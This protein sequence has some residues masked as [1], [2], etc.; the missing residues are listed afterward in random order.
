MTSKSNIC[1]AALA[2]LLVALIGVDCCY[3]KRWPEYDD[4]EGC[5]KWQFNC[6]FPGYDIGSQVSSGE[7]CGGLCINN[8][9]CNAFS[10]HH[11]TCYM[12]NIPA[13]VGRSPAE[14]GV[15]G[16]LPWKF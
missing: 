4:G 7:E 16:F 8:G 12:K 5:V 14:G 1:Y 11:G 15:C 10:H 13:D 6:D 2:L 3:D 9:G